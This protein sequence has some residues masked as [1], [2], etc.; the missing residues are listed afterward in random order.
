[1]PLAGDVVSGSATAKLFALSRAPQASRAFLAP[2]PAANLGDWN[3]PTVGWGLVVAESLKKLP[4]PLSLLVAARKAP[5]FRFRPNWEHSLTLLRDTDRGIDVDVSGARRGT[6]KGALP[7]YLLIYGD[8][9]Q[10]PW[11]LQFV[12]N[13]NRCVGR[14]HLSGEALANYVNALMNAFANEP[15]D[16]YSTVTWATDHGPD[17]IT[18]LMRTHIALKVHTKLQGDSEI[19]A[20]ARFLDGAT[21][22][23]DASRERLL[24]VLSEIKPGLIVTT[25]HGQTGPLDDRNSMLR[26]LGVP[27]DQEFRALDVAS[28]C[29]AWSPA[30]AVWYCHACCSA[31]SETPSAFA[32]LF[33]DSSD[34]GRVL[35]AVADLKS[36]VAPLPTALLGAKRPLRAFIGHV[37][38]T[39]D[40]TLRNPSTGQPLTDGIVSALYPNLFQVKPRTSVGHAFRDWYLKLASLYAMWG[41]ARD[42]YN[43]GARN[44]AELM[45]YQ[46]AARD[47]QSTVI[48]GD[49]AALLPLRTPAP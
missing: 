19:G 26:M 44:T 28:L 24:E 40:W 17:D 41:N 35:R 32:P 36:Q 4:D 30:G 25:S 14:L 20:R 38:P 5:V 10:I 18:R 37:E 23:A 47:V 11:A 42:L 21:T 34:I 6:A 29:N 8:P 45:L 22:P 16:P 15:A 1:M 12:L 43:V 3:D 46:L 9:E 27:V 7:Y 48:L 33:P 31:G 39:F 49:P 13:A 2:E